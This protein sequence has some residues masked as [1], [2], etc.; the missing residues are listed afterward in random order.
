MNAKEKFN[1]KVGDIKMSVEELQEIINNEQKQRI[2][3]CASEIQEILEKYG[4]EII[5]VIEI[6][7]QGVRKAQIEIHL[8]SGQGAQRRDL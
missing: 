1:E 3:T 5:P 7:S 4:C 6:T 8:A 2:D